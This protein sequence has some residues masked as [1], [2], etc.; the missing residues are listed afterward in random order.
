LYNTA[1]QI[2]SRHGF[3]RSSH[4]KRE[5]L[6]SDF[7]FITNKRDTAIRTNHNM[8]SVFSVA[9]RAERHPDQLLV[10]S[11]FMAEAWRCVVYPCAIRFL[12]T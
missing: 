11:I 12:K 8:F 10:S 3:E 2:L 9:L 4:L 1:P 5:I 7:L 6:S